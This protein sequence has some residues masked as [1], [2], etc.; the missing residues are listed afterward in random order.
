MV[1]D[2]NLG[3]KGI[4]QNI[5]VQLQG[6]SWLLYRVGRQSLTASMQKE[7]FSMAFLSYAYFLPFGFLFI[8]LLPFS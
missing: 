2:K 1:G 5:F 6:N 7:L 8:F 4:Y 3:D